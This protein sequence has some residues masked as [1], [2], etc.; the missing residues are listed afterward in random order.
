VLNDVNQAEPEEVQGDMHKVGG[1]VG[2][3]TDNI[4]VGTYDL[5]VCVGSDVLFNLAHTLCLL[6]V[7]GLALQDNLLT[8]GVGHLILELEEYLEELATED[9]KIL[10]F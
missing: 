8:E 3:Q 7:Q 9:G 2:H 1:A 4:R 10:L 5:R 6:H